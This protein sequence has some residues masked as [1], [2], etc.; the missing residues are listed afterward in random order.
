[1]KRLLITCF[2]ML[3]SVGGAFSQLTLSECQDRARANRP[4]I[5]QLAL[6]EKSKDVNLSNAS[7][8]WLPQF[9]I[10]A[11]AVAADGMPEIS[12]PGTTA[13]T[14]HF[15]LAVMTSLLQTV[16]DGG[17]SSAK[18][19]MTR[20]ETEV[21]KAKVEVS[22]YA[23]RSKVNELYFGILSINEQ[24]KQVDI[25]TENLVRNRNRAEISLQNGVIH[26]SDLDKIQVEIYKAE[27]SK[28]NLT[29][30]KTAYLK[31]L[32]V[33]IGREIG[34]NEM[35]EIPK[36]VNIS[37]LGSV[38]NRPE[39]TMFARRRE[40]I[41]AQHSLLST[42]I[43]P[44]IQLQ[45]MVT[46]LTPGMRLANTRN[47]HFLFGALVVQ[48]NIGGFYTRKNDLNL[49]KIKK[50][51]IDTQ[52]N[53]FM[54][55]IDVELAQKRSQL[56]RHRLLVEKDDEIVKLRE[57]VKS[58]SEKKFENGTITMSELIDDINA[59]N[60]AR[61]TRNQHQIEFLMYQYDIKN[62]LGEK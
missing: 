20:A 50:N 44:K 8:L 13:E 38:G 33:I 36:P 21:E 39:L 53:A 41:D 17:I 3:G 57:R 55:S 56:E 24:I 45:G 52:Q 27:L 23:I 15:Q 32:A 62:T 58:A 31:M 54:Q 22:L 6:I 35:L 60:L 59:E 9:G 25:L 11:M 37:E 61:Q 26:Q 18:V 43:T 47:N 10:S 4:I 48:W 30:Y 34:E 46:T 14:E 29:T 49:L 51:I 12:L 40:A 16:W 42:K 2:L 7:K 19:E 5:R 28:I 1:M